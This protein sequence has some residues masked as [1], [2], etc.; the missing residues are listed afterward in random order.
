MITDALLL[1]DLPV[2]FVDTCSIL[3][4]F[5]DP[6]RKTAKPHEMQAAVDVV[7]AAEM[8]TIHCF[9][10]EQ[11]KT[12]FTEHDL[13]VQKETIEKLKMARDQ[14]ERANKLAT[15]FG[16]TSNVDLTH[17]D[18]YVDQARSVVERWL[19]KLQTIIPSQDVHRR[20]FL[21]VNAKRAPATQGKESTK[22]CLIYETILEKACAIRA[23]DCAAPMVFLSS[24]T[25]D[26]CT[27]GSI[28]KG[29]IVDDFG[30]LDLQFASN[31]S[32][33]KHFLGLKTLT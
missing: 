17:L 23:A 16:V 9:M 25:K 13:R 32:A 19:T 2:L 5:R 22:D 12:E 8:G 7:R 18:D 24:N 14:I 20:A 31:M 3:D 11:V 10:A 26:Y 30:K 1:A 33:A 6:T 28:L 4:I 15:V 29:D 21:R 27:Q